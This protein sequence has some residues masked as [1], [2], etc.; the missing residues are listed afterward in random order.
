MRGYCLAPTPV[1]Q[2]RKGKTGLG[3]CIANTVGTTGTKALE[4][5]TK[6]SRQ[7]CRYCGKGVAAPE[8]SSAW[9]KKS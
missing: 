8:T 6:P 9:P 1:A 5:A 2:R 4:G 3:A 7:L